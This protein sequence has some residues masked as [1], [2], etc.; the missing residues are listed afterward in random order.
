MLGANL[1]YGER[2]EEYGGIPVGATGTWLGYGRAVFARF[3]QYF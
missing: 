3:A 2:G 1:P